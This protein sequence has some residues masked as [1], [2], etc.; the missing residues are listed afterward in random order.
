[1]ILLCF[2]SSTAGRGKSSNALFYNV[3]RSENNTEGPQPGLLRLYPGTT[4]VY[5]R[6]TK[7]YDV[8]TNMKVRRKFFLKFSNFSQK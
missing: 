4:E 6:N 5:N 2:E 3:P 1:M 8:E 7:Y